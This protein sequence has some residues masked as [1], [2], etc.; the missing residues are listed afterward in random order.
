RDRPAHADALHLDLWWQGL[1]ICVDPG[2]YLYY[3]HQPWFDCFRHTRVHNT[4][5]V[6][7]QDQMDR[8]YRFTWGNWHSCQLNHWQTEAPIQSMELE[9]HGY[10]R[11]SDPVTHRRAVLLIQGLYWIII[12]DLLGNA[13]HDLCL[14]WLLND[15]PE[16]R[17]GNK[18]HLNTSEGFYSISVHQCHAPDHQF[19]LIKGDPK[20]DIFGLRANYYGYLEKA[21]SLRLFSKGQLP[22][23]YISCFGPQGW[24]VQG[25]ETGTDLLFTNN[26]MQHRIALNPIGQN[27]ILK[28]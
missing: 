22:I 16:Q 1:N 15:F 3:G 13:S 24:K 27:Q 20:K 2:T 9:H 28:E 6:D 12:D 19:E 18:I 10:Q 26:E 14:H 25:I 21:M 8:A 5:C 7:D 17:Q 4:V 23:R 11:L